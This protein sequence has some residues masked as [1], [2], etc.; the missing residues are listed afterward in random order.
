M[1]LT[2]DLG[3]AQSNSGNDISEGAGTQ[4]YLPWQ[5]SVNPPQIKNLSLDRLRGFVSDGQFSEINLMSMME[6][7]RVSG[8]DNVTLK[9][10]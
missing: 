6:E 10:N 4:K 3:T 1:Q 5:G 8:E 7:G 2:V 9:V